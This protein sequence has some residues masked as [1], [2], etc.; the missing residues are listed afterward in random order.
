MANYV[1]FSTSEGFQKIKRDHGKDTWWSDGKYIR[2][3]LFPSRWNVLKN[4]MV[5]H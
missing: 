2:K 1:L 5:C 3:K 4:K